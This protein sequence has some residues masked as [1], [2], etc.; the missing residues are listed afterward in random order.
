MGICLTDFTLKYE[1]LVAV[2]IVTSLSS[3]NCGIAEVTEGHLYVN[4]SVVTS[5][6]QKTCNFIHGFTASLFATKSVEYA[7]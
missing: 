1:Y 6:Y 3:P 7:L 5:C 4:Q 2:I